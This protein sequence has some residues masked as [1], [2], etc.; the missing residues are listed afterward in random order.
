MKFKRILA[1]GVALIVVLVL[2]FSIF[3]GYQ[4]FTSSTNIVARAD[5]LENEQTMHPDYTRLIEPLKP[6]LGDLPSFKGDHDI[7]YLRLDP[8]LPKGTLIMVHG[9][10]GTKKINPQVMKIFYDMGYRVLS[11][12]QRNSGENQADYNTYGCL[13]SLDCLDMIQF[14]KGEFPDEPIILW[15]ESNGGATAILAASQANDWIDVLILDCPLSDG[16]EL[17]RQV[18]AQIEQDKGIPSSYL[19]WCGDLFTQLKI[20]VSYEDM[21]VLDEA[22]QLTM[23]VLITSS[24]ID[25]VLPVHMSPDIYQAIKHSDKK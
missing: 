16:S 14:A 5:T 9:L 6:E 3:I 7:P 15:G 21:N 23:P 20:G 24:S 22:S 19:N 4:V 8:D 25:Q 10:G 2:A 1:W 12:D 11:Y 18:F 17:I 13:E